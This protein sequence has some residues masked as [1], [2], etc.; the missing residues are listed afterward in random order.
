V[1]PSCKLRLA[2]FSARLKIQDRAE[3]GNYKANKE[4]IVGKRKEHYK[5]NKEEKKEYYEANK[6]AKK[7]YYEANK[8]KI[9]Q[10]QKITSTDSVQTIG[11]TGLIRLN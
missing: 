8:E 11:L 7:E 9:L 5:A 6:E 3:C 10:K 1:A 2:R 4:D